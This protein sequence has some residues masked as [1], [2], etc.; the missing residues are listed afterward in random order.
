MRLRVNPEG[1]GTFSDG[2]SSLSSGMESSF[3]CGEA[4]QVVAARMRRQCQASDGTP[5][6]IALAFDPRNSTH[7]KSIVVRQA[8]ENSCTFEMDIYASET[9][10]WKVSPIVFQVEPADRIA[11]EDVVFC[12]EE[13]CVPKMPMPTRHVLPKIYR[14]LETPWVH[15]F[16]LDV[17][18]MASDYP[19]WFLKHCL[20]VGDSMEVYPEL[21]LCPFAPGFSGVSFVGSD[22]AK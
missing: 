9:D 18:E 16:E 4:L 22:E 2:E 15:A 14:Y 7:Y 10:R 21:E 8:S 6:D 1:F 13:E 12:N 11:F 19:H 5:A 3:T 20:F 17:H